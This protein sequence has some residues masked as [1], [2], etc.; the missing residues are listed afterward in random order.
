M[1]RVCDREQGARSKEHGAG[2]KDEIQKAWLAGLEVGT[3][4]SK[5]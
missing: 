5:E 3:E 4:K 2:S 1:L